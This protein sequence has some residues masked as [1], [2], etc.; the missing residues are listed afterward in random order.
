MRVWTSLEIFQKAH[1]ITGNFKHPDLSPPQVPKGY[2]TGDTSIKMT[3]EVKSPSKGSIFELR[4]K[5]DGNESSMLLPG[6]TGSVTLNHLKVYTGYSFRIRRGFKNGTWGAFSKYTRVWTPAG[7]PTGPPAN[8]TAFNKSAVAIMVFWE[9][10]PRPHRNGIVVGYKVCYKR[11]DSVNSVMYCTAV[12][13]HGIELGGLKPF[14]PY[15]VTVLGYTTKGEGPT[16]EPV[17]V[18]TDQFVPSAAPKVLSLSANKTAI[19]VSWAPIPRKYVNGILR[20]YYVIYWKR[21]R[22]SPDNHVIQVNQST[23]RVVIT[24]LER[25]STYGLRLAGL[26]KVRA[27]LRNGALSPTYNVTT[28]YGLHTPQNVKVYSICS[29]CL[30]VT[31]DPVFVPIDENPLTGYRLVCRQEASGKTI[32]KVVGPTQSS[33]KLKYLQKFSSY[34][35]TVSSVGKN[36]LGDPSEAV[37]VTTL[38]DVPSRAPNVTQARSSGPRSIFIEWSPVPETYLHGILRGY[39]LYYKKGISRARRFAIDSGVVKTISVNKTARSLEVKGLTPFTFYEVWVTAYTNVGYGPASKPLTVITDEDVPSRAPRILEVSAISPESVFVKWEPIPRRHLQGHLQGYLLFYSQKDTRRHVIN[40]T[41]NSSLTHVTLDHMKPQT[42]YVVWI[43]GFTGKGAGPDSEREFVFTPVAVPGRPLNVR[44]DAESPRSVRITWQSQ[45]GL[46]G[47]VT[48]YMVKWRHV[49]KPDDVNLNGQKVVSVGSPYLREAQVDG[50][51]PYN[52]YSFV[53]REEVRSSNWSKF[54]ADV[55]FIMPEDVPSPP[56]GVFMKSKE[57]LRLVLQWRK[58]EETNGVI[59]KYVVHF[60]NAN[61]EN[62]TY[63]A[64]SE[65]D[66]ENVTHEFTL[67]DVEAEYKIKVQAYNSLPG[68]MSEEITVRHEPRI[69]ISEVH[70]PESTKSKPIWIVAIL[71][72]VILLLLLVVAIVL[73]RR[74]SKR[75]MEPIQKLS[76]ISKS[77]PPRQPIPVK[78]LAAHCAR[79]HANNNALFIDEF[80]SL[81]RVAWKS[82]WEASHA[83][84]NRG[85]NRYCNIVAYDHSRVVLKSVRDIAGSDYIN[86]N[87]VDGYNSPAKYIATQGPL[88]HTVNDFWRMVWEKNVKTIVMIETHDNNKDPD[89]EKYWQET[90]PTEYGHVTV[91]HLSSCAMTDWVV[92]EFIVWS[93]ESDCTEKR[94]VFQYHFTNWPDHGV[95]FDT[96]SFLMFHHKLRGAL[97][98]DPGPVLVHCS[99]GVGRTGC[100]IAIDSLME[101]MESEKVVDV[102]GF[103]TKMRKQRNFMVQTQEQYWFIHDVLR[104]SCICGETTISSN[105]LGS[106]LLCVSGVEPEVVEQRTAEFENL[107]V[108]PV[109]SL[110]FKD[111]MEHCN[112]RKNRCQETLPFD[113]NRVR[114]SVMPGELGSDY[115]NAS[116]I[117]SYNECQIYI[118]TQA[119]M[120]NTV[121][122]FWRMIW[123]QRSTIVVMLDDSEGTDSEQST[124]YWPDESCNSYGSIYVTKID[125]ERLEDLTQ[126]VFKLWQRG[127][128]ESRL[129]YHFQYRRWLGNTLPRAQ[130]FVYLHQQVHKMRSGNEREGSIVVH[131]SNGDG[132]TGV[133]LALSLSIER[134]ETEDSVDIFQTLRWL[135][136]QRARLVTSL[137]QYNYC[138]DLIKSYLAW[139][140]IN[141]IQNDYV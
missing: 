47:Q 39:Y 5:S 41:V 113:H 127:S 34:T 20:G 92:R 28:K 123:E 26:T 72:G 42:E 19:D 104:D 69:Q 50:L 58:P 48:R 70:N 14:T 121:G 22:M 97:S 76:I 68:R 36:E 13:A 116:F 1:L 102:Y 62:I 38:E 21:P 31:W 115:I 27:Y 101:Q 33:T 3:W 4:W 87:Y 130:S 64:Y 135:R 16:S 15:W 8:V 128:A 45:T 132:R 119:P 66:K 98:V 95:P 30:R 136:S 29:T 23:L 24:G 79:F 54:S 110:M 106:G 141:T 105:E 59:K 43:A 67:P 120:E 122:D 96:S 6:V 93:T 74:N 133:F 63:T 129:L 91:S 88:K 32:V 125:E 53:V 46:A 78:E 81:E 85:K 9:R 57:E 71:I 109:D 118:A 51:R 75:L 139:R 65:V 73:I 140:T 99:A 86:A 52:M 134:L 84:F 77:S 126:R 11:A 100:F 61:G 124:R 44:V 55:H 10:I 17:K 117:D 83:A 114:L 94:D 90:E 103:V 56:R 131:C 2:V 60:T 111:A 40:I 112:L 18:W 12:H 80:K 35:V 7:A 25:N 137:E 138:Y 37:T 82:S 49:G 107:Q 108:F 89:C